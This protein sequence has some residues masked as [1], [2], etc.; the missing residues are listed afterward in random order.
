[1]NQPADPDSIAIAQLLGL[2]TETYL[3][4]VTAYRAS[5]SLHPEIEIDE[6]APE[7]RGGVE[8][9]ISAAESE[10]SAATDAFEPARVRVVAF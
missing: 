3:A 7:P 10:D 9:L 8:A 2:S 1:M 6:S 4:K 5:P